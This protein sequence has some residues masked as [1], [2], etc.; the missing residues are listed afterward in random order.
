MVKRRGDVTYQLRQRAIGHIEL[1]KAFT[2]L[3]KTKRSVELSKG[4]LQFVVGSVKD[5]ERVI[6]FFSCSG[7][8][9]LVGLKHDNYA[10]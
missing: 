1:F 5:I 6:E 7:L 9:P 4:Y 8:H 3:F 10:R 2:L